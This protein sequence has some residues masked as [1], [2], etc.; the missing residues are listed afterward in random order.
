M[1]DCVALNV[2]FIF[3]RQLTPPQAAACECLVGALSSQGCNF[4][5]G[6]ESSLSGS[7]LNVESDYFLTSILHFF[8]HAPRTQLLTNLKFFQPV[9]PQSRQSLMRSSPS[10]GLTVSSCPDASAFLVCRFLIVLDSWSSLRSLFPEQICCCVLF[11]P[12][13]ADILQSVHSICA[14][15]RITLK[16]TDCKNMSVNG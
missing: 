13:D 9:C 12:V 6:N 7:D 8:L 5:L 1:F 15:H 16:P 3:K 4:H 10:L 11:V 14:I 2:R